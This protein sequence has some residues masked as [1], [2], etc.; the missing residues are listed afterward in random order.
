[1]RG[2]ERLDRASRPRDTGAERS[3]PDPH[4]ARALV[5]VEPHDLAEDVREPLRPVETQQHGHRASD[6]YFFEQQLVLD[7]GWRRDLRIGQAA[8]EVGAELVEAQRLP[9][10]SPAPHRQ[11]RV[12]R[13][14]EHPRPERALSAERLQPRDHA[15]Q[16]LLA[17]VLRILRV[18]EE[19]QCQP[20]DV[21]LDRANDTLECGPVAGYGPGHLGFERA[22]LVALHLNVLSPH[23][24]CVGTID[25]G[26]SPS[27]AGPPGSSA[28]WARRSS[29]LDGRRIH[30]GAESTGRV[31]PTG[32]G[33]QL[34]QPRKL[35]CKRA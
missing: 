23:C 30:S 9:F 22:L 27:R 13:H 6:A 12:R 16:D 14:A 21:R 32:G 25:H 17:R 34:L 3:R 29:R 11:Q 28:A 4:R 19:P 1:M 2:H 33:E 31:G 35:L 24:R 15:D 8:A 20:V 5:V 26:T 10:R 18:P 7:V